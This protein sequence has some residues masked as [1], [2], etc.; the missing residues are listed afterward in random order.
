MISKRILYIDAISPSGHKLYNEI[1]IKDILRD[2]VEVFTV[3][4]EGYLSDLP[5]Q[6]PNFHVLLEIPKKYYNR[7]ENQSI[8]K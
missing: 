7:L 2:D 4:K 8:F 3:S 5:I 1:L 6:H